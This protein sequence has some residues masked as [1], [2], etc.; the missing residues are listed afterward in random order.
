MKQRK[1]SWCGAMATTWCAPCEKVWDAKPGAETMDHASRLAEMIDITTNKRVLEIPFGK[2]QQR[3]E[4][5]MGRGVW[6]HEFAN[7]EA[8]VNELR[9]QTPSTFGDV[10]A[11]L[12]PDKLLVVTI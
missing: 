3:V 7:P 8:L 12:D 6:T 10:L 1:C 2:L 5:L 4:A 9:S 11:K